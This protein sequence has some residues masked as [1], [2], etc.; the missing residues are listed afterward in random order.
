MLDG[1]SIVIFIVTMVLRFITW[2]LHASVSN[3]RLLAVAAYLYGLNAMFLTLRVIGHIMESSKFT[4]SIQIALFQIVGAVIAIFGQFLAVI[5][6]FSLAITKVYL[7][8]MSYN[9]TNI[10]SSNGYV[11]HD[12]ILL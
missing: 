6:A 5:V 11:C 2:A 4:G 9:A 10:R 3:N 12:H 8:E 7:A 1:V